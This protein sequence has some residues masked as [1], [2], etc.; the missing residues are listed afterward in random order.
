MWSRKAQTMS[1]V[2]LRPAL[3]CTAMTRPGEAA[4]KLQASSQKAWTSHSGGTLQGT[5]AWGHPAGLRRLRRPGKGVDLGLYSPLNP[6]PST[7][8]AQSIA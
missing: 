7:G 2:R 1:P 4:R 8:V 6:C 5:G 3:Q